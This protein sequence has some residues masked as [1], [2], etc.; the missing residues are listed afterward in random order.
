MIDE[1]PTKIDKATIYTEDGCDDCITKNQIK[2]LQIYGWINNTKQSKFRG[3][4]LV[5]Y[6]F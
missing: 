4:Q 3:G 2:N 5:S 6:I 1:I